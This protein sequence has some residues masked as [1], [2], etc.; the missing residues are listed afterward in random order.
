MKRM[1][2]YG[3]PMVLWCIG[4]LFS[5]RAWWH[6]NWY[7]GLYIVS[8]VVWFLVGFPRLAEAYVDWYHERHRA[9]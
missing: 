6:N 8:M 2:A 9:N 7:Y 5:P 4:I 3:I 1:L